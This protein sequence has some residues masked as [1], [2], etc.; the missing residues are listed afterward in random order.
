MRILLISNIFPPGFIGGYELGALDVARGL[1]K[2]GHEVLVLTSDYFPD[3][4]NQ[5]LDVPTERVLQCTEPS[6]AMVTERS[7]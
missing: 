4:E 1:Q 5:M 6:R 7:L 3:D 2:C